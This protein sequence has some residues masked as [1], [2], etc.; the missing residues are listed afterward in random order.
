MSIIA[1]DSELKALNDHRSLIYSDRRV[2]A[3]RA[4]SSRSPPAQ[5]PRP[6]NCECHCLAN[7]MSLLVLSASD[8]ERI[9]VKFSPDELASLMARVFF[10]LSNPTS[11]SSADI[12]QPHRISLSMR[13]H[14]SLFMP[15]RISS[16]G[17]TMKVVSVPLPSA[18]QAAKEGGLPAS[19]VVLDETSGNVRA[20]VNARQL[21]ALRNSAG[22]C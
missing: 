2:T 1:I 6:C 16:M 8:V 12:Q 22:M 15:S 3:L 18:S 11:P 7:T 4:S 10:S 17:S 19:T 21:T 9:I 5:P 14:T 20:I 13:N